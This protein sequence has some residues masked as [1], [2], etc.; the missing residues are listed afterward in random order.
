MRD[1]I[2]RFMQNINRKTTKNKS[3]ETIIYIIVVTSD[4]EEMYSIKQN[5]KT[6]THN[7]SKEIN[8]K[9]MNKIHMENK[10]GKIKRD[11]SVSLSDKKI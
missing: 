3:K 11:R 5:I 1:T 6:N 4:G 8:E 7:V 10:V 2:Q 9:K